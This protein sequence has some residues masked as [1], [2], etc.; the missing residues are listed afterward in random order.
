MIRAGLLKL[1]P[2]GGV[3]VVGSSESPAVALEQLGEQHADVVLVDLRKSDS[4]G[5]AWGLRVKQLLEGTAVL[6]VR[7]NPAP[8]QVELALRSG[9][10]GVLAPDDE[11][12]QL[13]RAIEELRAGET[14]LSPRLVPFCRAQGLEPQAEP[15]AEAPPLS[16][17]EVE[18]VRW[19]AL[20]QTPPEIAAR[21]K[22]DEVLVRELIGELG[23]K[24]ACRSA[25][26]FARFAIQ[27]RLLPRD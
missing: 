21:C 19:L 11:E 24:L 17:L 1:L 7:E 25:A 8:D 9:I 27:H 6:V 15:L 18:I 14:F 10:D 16:E 20:G 22:L 4:D 2:A 3:D 12:A 5:F 13:F 26:S 23:T